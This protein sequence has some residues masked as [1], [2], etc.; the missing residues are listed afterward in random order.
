M[1]AETEFDEGPDDADLERFG[2]ETATCPSCGAEMWDQAE[3]CPSCGDYV[4]AG[5][6]GQPWARLIWIIAAILAAAGLL[7]AVLGIP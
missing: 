6:R 5:P 1:T 2:G 3:R 4:V 7:L